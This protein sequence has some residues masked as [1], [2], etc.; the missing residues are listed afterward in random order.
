[1]DTGEWRRWE[2]LIRDHGI[3][4]ER[5]RGHAHPRCPAMIYP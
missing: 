2:R 3:V 5:P 1:M 4:I